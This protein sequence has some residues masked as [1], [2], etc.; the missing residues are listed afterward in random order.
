MKRKSGIFFLG[1]IAGIIIG[2][3][4]ATKFLG[5]QTTSVPANGP[6]A[7]VQQKPAVPTDQV[8][9][10]AVPQKVYDI[11]QYIRRYHH[12]KPGYEG[13]RT[14]SNR[15][16]RLPQK[17]AQS[18]AIRYQ[19]WDVNPKI[20]G[21]NRGTERLVTGSDSSAWYTSDHYQSFI[22]ISPL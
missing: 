10:P 20:R 4:F 9:N 8:N 1:L 14:F 19:E 2:V 5:V 6:A 3:L 17:D 11:L 22:R 16:K 15:E 7:V 21:Q 12:A 18:H 13:G